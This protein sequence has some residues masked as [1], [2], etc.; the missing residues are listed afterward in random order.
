[1]FK[2]IL[3]PLDGSELAEEALSI[4]TKFVETNNA[5]LYILR[6]VEVET[7]GVVPMHPYEVRLPLHTATEK[8]EQS[9]A[10]VEHKAQ[11]YAVA[12]RPII[13]LIKRGSPAETILTIAE[14][15]EIDLIIMSTHGRSGLTR[16]ALGSVTERVLRHA[17]CP[18]M[19]IRSA[20]TIKKILVTLDGS[21][22]AESVILPTLAIAKVLGAEVTLLRVDEVHTPDFAAVAVLEQVEHGMGE[23]MVLAEYREA[24][25]YVQQL[26]QRYSIEGVRLH[27]A[28]ADGHVAKGILGFANDGDFDM[29]AMSTHGRSGIRRW[30]YGS[31]AEK[32]L[33]AYTGAMLVLRPDVENKIK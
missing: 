32:V 24:Q 2:N 7:L 21:E 5:Q 9:R 19:T 11:R 31:I 6:V 18:V 27:A 30:V 15:Y 10:Y 8:W 13:P 28:I 12:D 4:A 1:M 25:D 23:N 33:R 16:W 22:L 17:T 20:Q 14:D 26:V 3:V 29:I